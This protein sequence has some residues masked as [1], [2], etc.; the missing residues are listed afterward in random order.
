MEV[1]PKAKI[2][3]NREAMHAINVLKD[4]FTDTQE[5]KKLS[6]LAELVEKKV[7]MKQL[8]MKEFYSNPCL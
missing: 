3:S 8:N 7:V 2:I 1:D 6:E 4:Y 5:L